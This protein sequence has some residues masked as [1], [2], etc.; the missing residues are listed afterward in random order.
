MK[1]GTIEYEN[2][3]MYHIELNSHKQKG[4]KK[5]QNLAVRFQHLK[6]TEN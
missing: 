2:F 3:F 6:M 5:C 4:E 1:V